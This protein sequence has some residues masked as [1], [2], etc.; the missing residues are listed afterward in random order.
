MAAWVVQDL[1]E[2]IAM[3]LV[4]GTL[5]EDGRQVMPEINSTAC[6]RAALEAVLRASTVPLTVETDD[7]APR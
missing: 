5:D 6:Q 1:A 2:K 7:V 3:A 4:V